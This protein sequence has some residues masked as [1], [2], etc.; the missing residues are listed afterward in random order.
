MAT[1]SFESLARRLPDE[2]WSAFE[3][4]LPPV[5]W[6]GNG[7]PPCRNRDCLHAV[8]Y[9]GITG[10]GW[11]MLPPCFPS[12]KTVRR[13]WEKWLAEEAFHQ[14]WAACVGR[15]ELL[16]GINFDQLS[17]DGSRKTAKKGGKEPGPIL[18]IEANAVP[19]LC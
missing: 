10:I 1:F 7:R 2:V 11:K 12:Y 4:V 18:L 17:I 9:L 14:V 19:R 3:P 16:R 13:R 5:I 15:Y 8:I 6:C